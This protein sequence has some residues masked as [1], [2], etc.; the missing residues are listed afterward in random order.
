[1]GKNISEA[2]RKLLLKAQQGEITEALIYRNLAKKE[3]KP[4]NREVLHRIAQ[5]EETHGAIW[6]NYTGVDVKPKMFRVF[7]YTW[8]A[9]ILGLTFGLKLMEKGEDLAQG[10]YTKIA[11]EVPEALKI[12]A[13]EKVHE[14]K[15]LGLLAEER[16]EY[17][18]SIVLGLNDALVEL[19]GA[20]AGFTLAIQ[21]TRIT[22]AVGLITGIAASFSMAAS[23]YLSGKAD[24]LTTA[25]ALKSSVYTGLAYIITVFLL[26]TPYLLIP[27]GFVALGIT[28]TTAILIILFFNFYLSVAKD[29]PFTRR[30]LEMAFISLGVAALSFGIGAAVRLIFGIEV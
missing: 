13:D 27:T 20:L 17:M 22:A 12:A 23:E 6:K 28:L 9:R 14:Q 5:E 24:G 10:F 25:K 2:T 3:K 18:G 7:L 4:E 11:D 19:T 30:F 15:L 29:L 21:D 26:I 16:L 8:I 1:M